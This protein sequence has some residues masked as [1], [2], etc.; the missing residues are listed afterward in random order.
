MYS[1]YVYRRAWCIPRDSAAAVEFLLRASFA[2]VARQRDEH[3]SPR[4]RVVVV[5]HY[6]TMR[7]NARAGTAKAN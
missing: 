4:A 3:R 7:S 2:T 5:A 6:H 1:I